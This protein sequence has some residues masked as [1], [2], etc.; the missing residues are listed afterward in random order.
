MEGPA[1][2]A[3]L[4]VVGGGLAGLWTA[5][6]AARDGARVLLATRTPLEGSSS[7]WA[8]GG[9]AAALDPFDAPERHAADTLA[10]GRGACRPS[11]VDV[12]VDEA[13]ARV[14]ELEA[15]GVRFDSDPGGGLELALEGGHGHRRV[16][17]AGGSA[18]GRALTTVLAARVV[19]DPA[20]RVLEPASATALWVHEGRCVGA[21]IELPDG[22]T[23]PVPARAT[24]LATGGAAALWARTTNPSGAVGSGL[25]LAHAAGAALADLEFVQF[26]PTAL[27]AANG[28]DGF[29][30]T[31]ALRGE[32]ARLLGPDGE[33]FIDELAPRDE[34][35]MA[36][37][38]QLAARPG[39]QVHLDLRGIALER[40]PNVA[41]ALHAEG[42]NPRREPVR[43]AP[44]AHYAMGGIATDLHARTTVP[45]LY[46]IG[47]CACT[48]LHG[49][50]RLASNSLAECLVFGSRAEVAVRDEPGLPRRTDPAPRVGLHLAASPATRV[51][52]WRRAGMERDA[53]G[54]R[55]LLDDPSPLARLIALSALAREE[56]RGAH[57]RSDHPSIDPALDGRHLVLRGEG[58]PERE[59]WR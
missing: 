51:A 48:G 23:L 59:R 36:I 15:L 42:L 14:R 32:G 28:H 19:R 33:R 22:A 31:E 16:A 13:P 45:G 10:A 38:A 34:V 54:L 47:E 57:R 39:A 6:S 58:E 56:T 29:L 26:H 52:L 37:S 18:T 25:L 40:F 30:L 43:V 35:A 5:W 41:A 11:A 17:H 24:A 50:N 55:E 3:D 1:S 46:A 12:L 8:Q 20:I 2:P 4:L 53:D 44:A 9:V 7:F 49:A 27:A 21:L